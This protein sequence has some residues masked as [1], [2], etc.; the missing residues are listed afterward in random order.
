MSDYAARIVLI[1]DDNGELTLNLD[2]PGEVSMFAL[3]GALDF[4]KFNLQGALA[5]SI[6][7]SQQE[8][9]DA[10]STVQCGQEDT[11]ESTQ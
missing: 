8:D 4:I 6:M 11:T 5:D 7:K 10:N 3:A 1:L 9:K 2:N